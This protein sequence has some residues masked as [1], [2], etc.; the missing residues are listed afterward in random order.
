MSFMKKAAAAM[1]LAAGLAPAWAQD[2]EPDYVL[3]EVSITATRIEESVLD[4][5]PSVTIIT[6]QDME[7]RGATTV[8]DA[9]RAV[10]GVVVNDYG[11]Q[12]S[13]KSM[14]IR[15]ST[16][17]Q[18]L[19]LVDGIRVNTAL[20]GSTDLSSIP[21]ENIERIEV[22]HAGASALYG[23]DAVGGV[24]N[25]ITRKKSAIPLTVKIE[26]GGYIPQASTRDDGSR[27]LPDAA[28]LLDMQK[29]SAFAAMD[30]ENVD[31]NVSG[32][33]TRASNGYF[34]EDENGDTRKRDNAE[35]K[36]ADGSIG[37]RL[38]LF[39]GEISFDSA[40]AYQENRVPG[41]TAYLS[42][43]ARETNGKIN[44]AVRYSTQSFFSDLFTFSLTIDGAYS[45]HHYK[46]P[47]SLTDSTHTLA[48][49][50][51]EAEQRAFVSDVLSFLYGTSF[52][53][54][55]ADSTDVDRH[56]RESF[57]VFVESDIQP[58]EALSL[59]PA[60]RLDVYSDFPAAISWLLGSVIKLSNSD[61]LKINASQSY[62]P[63][64]FNELYWEFDGYTEGNPDL[65][66]ETGYSAD[67]GYL[68][69]TKEFDFSA[70]VFV[71]YVLDAILWQPGS[72]SVWRTEN[73]GKAFY[74][75]IETNARMEIAAG[76]FAE[77][78]YTFLYSFSLTD[79]SFSDD[80]RMPW[81]PTHTIDLTL[82]YKADGF[83][84]TLTGM[85]RSEKFTDTANTK[86]IPETFV[87]N[88]AVRYEVGKNLA[89]SVAVDNIF[90]SSYEVLPG[91][92]MP[93]LTIRSGMEI[94]L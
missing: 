66:P 10:P 13:I 12:G 83:T 22:L 79:Y 87:L 89:L 1:L 7:A 18:V 67:V 58:A 23:G 52:R 85:Y 68:H 3:D 81:I 25:V 47:D 34:Y 56:M 74:P 71:R 75:G 40:G 35:I 51:A 63:P 86:T 20:N 36:G 43:N 70:S 33:V 28:S 8:A 54:D 31:V 44:G 21:V 27:A 64:T 62:R 9:L 24:V 82:G 84:C 92:P 49:I 72:D 73:Y 48:N 45:D 65:K 90:N 42:P 11:G 61:S 59:R 46:D 77:A 60:V 30:G 88:G 80:I 50:G 37:I 41:S 32:G 57:G 26:N 55:A 69:V 6:A 78:G 53:H 91:Y 93:G 76:F 17:A 39:G 94:K 29:V 15:G 16:A 4:T 2:Q 5:P 38:P 19:V 14:F